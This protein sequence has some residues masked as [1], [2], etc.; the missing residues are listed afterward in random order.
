[1]RETQFLRLLSVPSDPHTPA[2]YGAIDAGTLG[3]IGERFDGVRVDVSPGDTDVDHE[4][5]WEQMRS[6]AASPLFALFLI[7]PG[8]IDLRSGE[9]IQK[10]KDFAV[11]LVNAGYGE[12]GHA[13]VEIGN[14]PDLAVSRWKKDP[15]AMAK[16]FAEC[17]A[18]IKELLPNMPVL[19]PSI[20]NLNR[21]GLGYLEKMAPHLPKG[22]AIAFHR[23][24]NGRDWWAPHRGFD[25][26]FQEVDC[27]RD[28]VDGRELWCTENG[29]AE[30]N[31]DYALTENE[32]AERMEQ[33]LAFWV[34]AKV[35]CW[36]AYQINS[37][38]VL[39]SDNDD[40]R[41]EKTYGARRPDL[42]WKPWAERIGQWNNG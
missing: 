26:R 39:A 5:R 18:A 17:Y 29:H 33:E 1:M 13:A 10:S 36:T 8:H 6:L 9:L 3:Q 11:K 25:S 41:R 2:T 16:T 34:D 35:R 42:T 21:R 15:A 30:Q 37:G 28:L 23:Y 24:P 27:L 7:G 12:R 20:S 31:S 19:S 14:E 38:D 4:M 40:Q 32:V 22:C